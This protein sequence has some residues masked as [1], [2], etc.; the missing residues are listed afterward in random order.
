[1]AGSMEDFRY[2]I[3]AC[4]HLAVLEPADWKMNLAHVAFVQ[5][6]E[7]IGQLCQ[8]FA[9]RKMVGM[10]VGVDD[11][12]DPHGGLLRCIQKP[13][14]IASHDIHRHRRTLAATSVEIGQGAISIAV[15]FEKHGSLPNIH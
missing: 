1:M 9:A 5:A 6:V 8:L 11:K 15:L 2:H 14:F 12:V 4:Q 3:T 7:A 13:L 10:D